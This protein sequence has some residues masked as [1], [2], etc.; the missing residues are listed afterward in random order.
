MK[1]NQRAK[2]SLQVWPPT[3]VSSSPTVH[4]SSFLRGKQGLVQFS[5]CKESELSLL[6]PYAT[7]EVLRPC[8]EATVNTD[9]YAHV[10]TSQTLGTRRPTTRLHAECHGGVANSTRCRGRESC[11][12][13]SSFTASRS[14]WL[15][16]HYSCS[17]RQQVGSRPP[18]HY[19]AG[20]TSGPLRPVRHAHKE[21]ATT[22]GT[23]RGDHG[24]IHRRTWRALSLRACP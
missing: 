7:V 9:D 23:C 16:A 4:Y 14:T 17:M 19:V 22:G 12:S 13:S 3:C 1:G 8:L 6:T 20:T 21:H 18:R 15:A 2:P 5:M 11:A 10:A 24:V